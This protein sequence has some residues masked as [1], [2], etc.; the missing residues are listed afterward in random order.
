MCGDTAG[1]PAANLELRKRTGTGPTGPA[2]QSPHTHGSPA[3]A[4]IRTRFR[5]PGP[6]RAAGTGAKPVGRS[7]P[8][9]PGPSA[10]RRPPRG[11]RGA[12]RRTPDLG[13]DSAS[14]A[15]TRPRH[16]T[17]RCVAVPTG[18]GG[19]GRVGDLR[20][21][22]P[23]GRRPGGRG[24]GGDAF[25]DGARRAPEH[26]R[27]SLAGLRTT[28]GGGPISFDRPLAASVLR[29]GPEQHPAQGPSQACAPRPEVARSSSLHHRRYAARGAGAPRKACATPLAGGRPTIGG[30]P[31]IFAPPPPRASGIAAQAPMPGPWDGTIQVTLTAS[32]HHMQWATGALSHHLRDWAPR[33]RP[34]G[35]PT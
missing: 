24:N 8:A 15:V 17:L 9:R 21:D 11:I 22:A 32:G 3:G 23:T 6:H 26:V 25:P 33:K 4:A 13:P 31:I 35:A 27:I 30:G 20:S 19:S 34:F 10:N 14:V 18:R 16:S 7:L 29:R 1:G 12:K 28:T 2:G 5:A